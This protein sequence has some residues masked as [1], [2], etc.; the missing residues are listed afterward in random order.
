VG[1]KHCFFKLIPPRPGFPADITPDQAALMENHGVYWAE[2]FSAGR[3][4][5]YGP[6]FASGN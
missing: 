3:V 2:H 5:A 1:K 4:L 6:V